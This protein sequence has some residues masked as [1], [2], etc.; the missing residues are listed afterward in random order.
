MRLCI[1]VPVKSP[2]DDMMACHPVNCNQP[3]TY[4]RNFWEDAGAK[5]DTQWYC[6][7]DV[8]AMETISESVMKMQIIPTQARI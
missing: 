6:P 5:I 4:P 1:I 7:P 3:V 2:D 8:G